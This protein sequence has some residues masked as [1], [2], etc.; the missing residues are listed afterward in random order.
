MKGIYN[1]L[2]II[3]IILISILSL[4]VVL[5]FF[6]M[7]GMHIIRNPEFNV[8]SNI[9]GLR[10]YGTN[11][12]IGVIGDS[13]NISIDWDCQN[14]L[15]DY[16]TNISLIL[17]VNGAVLNEIQSIRLK[18]NLTLT[19]ILDEEGIYIFYFNK[20]S[21]IDNKTLINQ[22]IIK[23]FEVITLPKFTEALQQTKYIK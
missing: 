22:Q 7:T 19:Y 2:Q 4:I 23:V 5:Y 9:S 11:D 10:D 6:N 16:L 13:I 12:N 3:L 14:H 17:K 15:C 8:N 18:D 1:Y 21:F 20:T